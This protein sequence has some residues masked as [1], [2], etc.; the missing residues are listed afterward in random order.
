MAI[1]IGLLILGI[2]AGL[3]LGAFV[4]TRVLAARRLTEAEAGE[5]PPDRRGAARRRTRSGARRRS[6]RGSKQ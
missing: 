1:S 5:R 6:R 3:A 2:L 4:G